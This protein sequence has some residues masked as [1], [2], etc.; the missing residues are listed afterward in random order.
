MRG[1][2]A[3]IAVCLAVLG[4]ACSGGAGAPEATPTKPGALP[5]N[6]TTIT[7]TDFRFQPRSLQV[8]VGTRVT[9]S[10]RGQ[11]SHRVTG[12]F[13]GEAVDSGELRSGNF[14]F[15]FMEPGVF[16]YTCGVHGAAMS[17][18]VIVR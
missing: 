6:L 14:E 16:D 1:R 15:E 10:F 9:W 13:A 4:S 18:Q 17:G 5:A 11:V 2:I 3:V 7:V 12:T 8:P